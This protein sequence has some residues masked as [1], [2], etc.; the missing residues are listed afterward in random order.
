MVEYSVPTALG[1]ER[2]D[3]ILSTVA[4][5]SRSASRR[6]FDDELVTSGGA[7]VAASER[8]DAGVT[9]TAS[10]E[11][12]D[13]VIGPDASVPFD[14]AYL[15]SDVIVIDKPAGVVVHPGAGVVGG[16]LASGLIARYPELGDLPDEA[17]WGIVHRLDKDTSGLLLVARNADAHR[18]LQDALRSRT[19]GREYV[20]LVSGLFD[21][22]TG[23]IEAP[24]GRDPAHPT[25]M[26][27]LRSGRL[28]A[29]RY[30][31]RAVWD[32]HNL[33]LLDVTLET[34]RTHQIR[35][36]LRAIGHPV[37]GDPQYGRPGAPGD[38]GRTWLHA[39]GL[40]FDHPATGERLEVRSPLPD[41]LARSLHS[42]GPPSRGDL[43]VD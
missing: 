4:G 10:I 35:V 22:A 31:R 16:T 29:T 2:A 18:T 23:T 34:G 17:R 6:L 5:I 8:L 24:I 41:D 20:A 30:R 37:V 19:V 26:T 25:R 13:P 9:M 21:S 33:T 15:D 39:T 38:P 43:P 12:K 7:L 1:G 36:H 40:S 27:V 14:V 28:A 32:S 3:R 42:L 11:D